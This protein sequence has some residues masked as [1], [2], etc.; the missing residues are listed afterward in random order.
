MKKVLR[1]LKAENTFPFTIQTLTS[2]VDKG[3]NRQMNFINSFFS[4]VKDENQNELIET[5]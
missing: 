4:A 5:A 2:D 1:K 3:N